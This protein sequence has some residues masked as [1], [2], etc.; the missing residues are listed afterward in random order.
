MRSQPGVF[1]GKKGEMITPADI[2]ASVPREQ[3]PAVIIALS[4]RLQAES[5]PPAQAEEEDRIIDVAAAA[6]LLRMS[7]RSIRR[8]AADGTIPAMRIGN[9]YQF[10]RNALLATAKAQ[11]PS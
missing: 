3:I 8:A 1:R 10:S 11:I 2:A 9:R 6:R 4:A 5:K 7:Q